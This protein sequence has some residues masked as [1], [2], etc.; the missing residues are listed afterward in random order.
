M[1]SSH[2]PRPKRPGRSWPALLLAALLPWPAGA[3]DTSRP[4]GLVD[5]P[6]ADLV[7]A[8]CSACHSLQLVIQNRGDAAHWKKLIRWM[9]ADHKLWD[10][11]EA[12]P[13]ILDYLETHYGAPALSPRRK[14]L[15][16][17]W[18]DG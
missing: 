3:G 10:L 17:R 6:G 14:P 5:A 12:E 9:Q 7:A 18:R 1:P 15:D 11:G 8:H 4:D 13:Q 16:T 2:T